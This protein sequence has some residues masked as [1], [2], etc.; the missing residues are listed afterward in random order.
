M[1]ENSVETLLKRASMLEE[2][3]DYTEALNIYNRILEADPDNK[4]ANDT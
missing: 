4:K 2:E 3:K 1:S